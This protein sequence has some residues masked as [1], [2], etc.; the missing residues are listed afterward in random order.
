MSS[1]EVPHSA[2]DY[3]EYCLRLNIHGAFALKSL[4][5]W[6]TP[7]SLLI[8]LNSSLEARGHR[9]DPARTNARFC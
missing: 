1:S 3:E 5:K 7:F 2:K 9:Y 4:M 6:S 8:A